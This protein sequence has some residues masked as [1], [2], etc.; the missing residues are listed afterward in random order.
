MSE[1]EKSTSTQVLVQ[2]RSVEN[3]AWIAQ[4]MLE[5]DLAFPF[6]SCDSFLDFIST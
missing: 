4:E 5:Y 6:S 1:V 3:G 2:I